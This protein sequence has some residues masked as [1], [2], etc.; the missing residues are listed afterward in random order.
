M[1]TDAGKL[2]PAPDAGRFR[3]P[4]CLDGRDRPG[5]DVQGFV[6]ES[7]GAAAAL[8]RRLAGTS[9]L[10]GSARIGMMAARKREGRP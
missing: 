5:H 3:A 7:N 1:N 4:A 6:V 10:G 2:A 8:L 9:R